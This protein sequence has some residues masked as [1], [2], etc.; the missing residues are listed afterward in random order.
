MADWTLTPPA[1]APAEVPKPGW[2]IT[3]PTAD[4]VPA[5]APPSADSG[6]TLTPPADQSTKP[7]YLA[8]L[9]QTLAAAP[10]DVLPEIKAEGSAALQSMRERTARIA[11]ENRA[12]ERAPFSLEGMKSFGKALTEYPGYATDALRLATAPVTGATEALISKPVSAATGG[13]LKPSDVDTALM[14]A[15]PGRGRVPRLGAVEGGAETAEGPKPAPSATETPAAAPEAKPE[16]PP[17]E[18]AGKPDSAQPGPVL[19]PPV[20]G[21]GTKRTAERVDDG[22]YRLTKNATADKIE[23]RQFLEG[24]PAEAIDP[25]LQA[26]V[27]R[28]IEQQMVDPAA[29]L[30]PDVQGFLDTHLKP[31][32]DEEAAL[33]RQIQAAGF[34]DL[35]ELPRDNAGYVHRVVKGKGTYFD[36]A[37]PQA[38][39]A[40]PVLGGRSLSKKASSLQPRQFFVAETPDGARKFIGKDESLSPGDSAHGGIVKPATTAE[41][42]ANTG[43]RYHQNA[44]VNTVDNVLRLRRVK[45]NIDLLDQL[46]GE[47]TERGLFVTRA[48]DKPPPAGYRPVDIP[49]LQG[50]W[51]EPRVAAVLKDFY[52]ARDPDFAWLAKANRFMTGALFFTPIP[53]AGNVWAHWA[54]GRGWDWLKPGAYR[55]LMKSGTRAI[56]AVVEQNDDYKRMLREGSGLLYG[57]VSNQN[58]YKLMIE[59]LGN[60]QVADPQTWAGIAKNLGF[61]TVADMVKWEYRAASKAL[62]A[63]NDMF[64]LQRQFELERQGLPVR[65]AIREAERD[66]PNYRVPSEVMGSRAVAALIKSPYAV[67]FGRYKYGQFRAYAEIIKP[68]LKG[69]AEERHEAAGKLLVMGLL[70]YGAYPL[71][72]A[73]LKKVTGNPD[74]QAQ[75]FGPFS[76]PEALTELS[77]GQRDWVSALSSIIS[78]APTIETGTE[79]LHNRDV[80]GREIINPE[81]TGLGKAVQ[82]E[83]YAVGKVP[84][85]AMVQ[86]G[87]TRPGGLGQSLGRAVGI[88]LP[89]AQAAARREKGKQYERRQA[90]GRERKDVIEQYLRSLEE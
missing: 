15:A 4:A 90:R 16:T 11:E 46:K 82:A 67:M 79:V 72:D 70:M 52:N 41:I 8:K 53:H 84:P 34:G 48:A 73:A 36:Q 55:E 57:D 63:V 5:T 71:A 31:W 26:K 37:D 27:Y 17:V 42:E 39:Q 20:A 88:K 54:V 86:Q 13:I 2:V 50:Y 60:E 83:E 38:A 23:A 78:P 14:A 75:R 47:L 68:L 29:P 28:E 62:W 21:E 19:E 69:S 25:A 59:K 80:F 6:W 85:A 1:A 51:A 64:M 87:L 24:L 32:R 33:Y 35:A 61:G 58:F 44:A 66:I 43:V 22:L 40:D 3:P 45:R 56:A 18:A 81:S 30:S 10:G 7:G 65:A 74:A 49:Q 9:G 77:T 12:S 76:V 89:D